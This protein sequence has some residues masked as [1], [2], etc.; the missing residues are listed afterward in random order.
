MTTAALAE[1]ATIGKQEAPAA[2]APHLWSRLV[3]GWV[4]P[5]VRSG[6]NCELCD[7]DTFPLPR[8]LRPEVVAAEIR[9]HWRR[10]SM[11]LAAAL[12]AMQ[13][14]SVAL[15]VA[16]NLV[17]ATCRIAQPIALGRIID[18]LDGGGVSEEEALWQCFTLLATSLL[19][20]ALQAHYFQLGRTHI[21]TRAVIACTSLVYDKS[22]RISASATS[23]S[24]RTACKDEGASGEGTNSKGAE[25]DQGTASEVNL[26]SADAANLLEGAFWAIRTAEYVPIIAAAVALLF[27]HLGA[28]AACSGLLVLGLAVAAQSRLAKRQHGRSRRQMAITDERIRLTQQALQ[29]IKLVKFG[30]HEGLYEARIAEVRAR[31]LVELRA[32]RMLVAW[33]EFLTGATSLMVAL[34]AFGTFVALEGALA[35]TPKRIFVSIALFNLLRQPLT[36]VPLIVETVMKSCVSLGR[37]EKYLRSEEV[38]GNSGDEA[39]PE[40][41]DA[42]LGHAAVAP[43]E[44]QLALSSGTAFGWPSTASHFSLTTE[45]ALELPPPEAASNSILCAVVGPVGCGKSTLLSALLSEVPAL[46]AAL[47]GP[48]KA[49][50]SVAYAAQTPWIIQGSVRQNVV[51]SA[52]AGA[53][54]A[55]KASFEARYQRCL[56]ACALKADLA[57]LPA[58]DETVIGEKGVNISG[59]Q[60]QRVSLA[61]AAMANAQVVLLDDPL[62]ALDARVA[63]RVFSECICGLLLGRSVRAGDAEGADGVG[64]RARVVVLVTHQLSLLPR[65]DHVIVMN[66]GRVV[67]Q[68]RFEE[69]LQGGGAA[70]DLLRKS[71]NEE[72]P[73]SGAAADDEPTSTPREA[74][75]RQEFAEDAVG[76]APE[77]DEKAGGLA[78]AG[79]GTKQNGGVVVSGSLVVAEDRARGT[80]TADVV[81]AYVAF[82]GGNK[83]LV[84]V[85]LANLLVE[86]TLAMSDWWLALWIEAGR[87]QAGEAPRVL[88]QAVPAPNDRSFVAV[89]MGGYAAWCLANAGFFLHRAVVFVK[90]CVRAAQKCHEQ[91]LSGVLRAPLSFFDA[92]PSGRVVNRFSADLFEIE[93]LLPRWIEHANQCLARVA[94]L[95]LACVTVLP[96]LLLLLPPM[97]CVFLSVLRLYSRTFRQLKRMVQVSRSP[98]L[99]HFAQTIDGRVT[100]RAF[101]S[102]VK[103]RAD[104]R[105]VLAEHLRAQYAMYSV[106]NWQAMRINTLGAVFT[107]ATALLAVNSKGSIA[108]ALAAFALN[109]SLSLSFYLLGLIFLVATTEATLTSCE[110]ILEY[111]NTSSEAPHVLPDEEEN[112]PQQQEGGHES[113]P[114]QGADI[115]LT[116][117]SVRYAPH[118]PLAL[119]GVNMHVSGG[120][121]MAGIVG[122]SGAGKSTLVA[123]LFRVV[124]AS[125]GTIEIGGVDIASLGLRKL[126]QAL[127]VILQEPVLVGRSVRLNLDPHGQHDDGALWEALELASLGAVVKS[128]PGGLD[129]EVEEGG[130]NFSVGTRQLLCMARALVQRCRV[131]VLDEATS[132]LDQATDAAIQG[133]V[134]RHFLARGVTV[135]V[136]AHRLGTVIHA[137]E[138]FVME[139]GRVAEHGPPTELL[140]R[141]SGAFAKLVDAAGPHAAA[142]LRRQAASHPKEDQK[143][144]LEEEGEGVTQ[145]D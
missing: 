98:L 65:V 112:D 16:M 29:G 91:L 118:L 36:F 138:I 116:N 139:H 33:N 133:M 51:F 37:M 43:E 40:T 113:W 18:Y 30:G 85:V 47:D 14:G 26:I 140:Q 39:E 23:A 120:G 12:F 124:E 119:C 132:S 15:A 128:L 126:R 7:A 28:G 56:S 136:V 10:G 32:L 106:Q 21:G 3:F 63:E 141:G 88:G 137:D 11:P 17:S 122:R 107:A 60:R 2:L 95:V 111:A 31:E 92:N 1:S 83:F 114:T 41:S 50:G 87:A 130:R 66:S 22:L 48:P 69:L 9:V 79:A 101:S 129:A 70:A 142:K 94:M 99:S 86:S 117:V 68:G 44:V 108:P 100:V 78:T 80:V 38:R 71:E 19:A 4:R 131:L 74:S 121:R 59:G 75:Q 104:F 145:A 67:A 64:G 97:A 125:A 93:Q 57:M 73:A 135:I 45:T 96:W 105:S 55:G 82:T 52:E 76:V 53:G 24:A 58:G 49:V 109:F 89:F 61:R 46:G 62:S 81:R 77:T 5:L 8:A 127:S 34:A 144:A 42:A 6:F 35:L 27:V 134:R 102:Q 110:R 72:A 90:G 143:S 115:T 123:A 20:G 84:L 103:M 13:R 25:G 54:A